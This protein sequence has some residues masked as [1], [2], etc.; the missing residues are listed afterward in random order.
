MV[1]KKYPKMG[2]TNTPFVNSLLETV[3]YLEN[4]V[5][6]YLSILMNEF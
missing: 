2:F 1:F 3:Y 5:E 6:Y 4:E